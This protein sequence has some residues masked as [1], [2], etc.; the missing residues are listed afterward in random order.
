MPRSQT[1]MLALR[2]QSTVI[3]NSI[4]KVWPVPLINM[5]ISKDYL[6]QLHWSLCTKPNLRN[7]RSNW[8]KNSVKWFQ[9]YRTC[10]TEFRI[11]L[12]GKFL[13]RGLRRHAL[14]TEII[15]HHLASRAAS[16]NGVWTITICRR[17]EIKT[18][19][20]MYI[21]WTLDMRRSLPCASTASTFS[22]QI[23]TR[24]YKNNYGSEYPTANRT[25]CL[26]KKV[27]GEN[28]CVDGCR[29]WRAAFTE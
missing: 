10:K 12:I 9:W 27:S 21:N 1:H 2:Q 5:R 28:C 25:C 6:T 15:C 11:M 8:V 24:V 4:S 3:H 7:K 16:R 29:P 19:S 14:V 20:E 13:R 17:G 18:T 22:L 23:S 26:P